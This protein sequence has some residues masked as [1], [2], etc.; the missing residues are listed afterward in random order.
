MYRPICHDLN[1]QCDPTYDCLCY[2]TGE[3]ETYECCERGRAS[4]ICDN[5]LTHKEAAD[6]VADVG[7]LARC[8]GV[9]FCRS[10]PMTTMA[11]PPTT[12]PPSS[13][14]SFTLT[15]SINAE[16]LKS[17]ESLQN[18]LQLHSGATPLA[19]IV[20]NET[21]I[22]SVIAVLTL[23]WHCTQCKQALRA[24]LHWPSAAQPHCC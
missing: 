9:D 17:V 8:D 7:K 1:C 18:G 12:T 6:C 19:Y 13:K 5:P 20:L 15:V 21:N 2:T 23:H 14:G 3:E 22:A 11:P 10:C 24:H 16:S 4:D